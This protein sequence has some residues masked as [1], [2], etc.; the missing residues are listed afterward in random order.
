MAEKFLQKIT[1]AGVLI[2]E[3]NGLGWESATDAVT[4]A[5]FDGGSSGLS[6]VPELVRVTSLSIVEEDS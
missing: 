1:F 2:V 5:L 4:A 6:G 3:T